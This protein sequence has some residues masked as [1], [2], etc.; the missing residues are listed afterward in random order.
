MSIHPEVEAVITSIGHVDDRVTELRAV[1]E[2]LPRR[3]RESVHQGVIDAASD[4][5]LWASMATS[6]QRQARDQA[7][8]WLFGGLRSL[9]S[10]LGWILLVIV[11]VWMV[12]G[13][14]AVL[15]FVK[16]I[17]AGGQ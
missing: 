16:T 12:G 8:G 5:A 9:V 2:D 14:G 3:M 13:P 4:P 1:T 6:L 10:R 15:A 7:G 11:A 17:I